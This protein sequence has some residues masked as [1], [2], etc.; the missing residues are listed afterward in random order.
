[1]V[2]RLQIAPDHVVVEVASWDGYLS[3]AIAR[4]GATIHAFE[5]NPFLANAFRA[6]VANLDA[7]PIRDGAADRVALMVGLHHRERGI[8]TRILREARRVLR[9]GGFVVVAEVGSDATTAR[10][11]N[12]SLGRLAN[13]RGDF[14]ARGELADDLAA[15]GL[16]DTA[17]ETVPCEWRFTS[18]LQAISYVRGMFAIEASDD[19]I[20]AAITEVFGHMLVWPWPL[21]FAT[22]HV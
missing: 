14:Y 12:G 11:L 3:R 18:R 8:R 20:S 7:L 17:E 6:R 22:G 5:T 10:F 9:A 16:V 2:R 1:M 4:T 15:A 13:H 21:Q 19:E